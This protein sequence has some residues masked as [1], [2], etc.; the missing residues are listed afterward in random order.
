M[1]KDAFLAT[2][3]GLGLG[4]LVTGIF[5]LGPQLAKSLPHITFPTITFPQAKPQKQI[6]PTPTPMPI[7]FAVSSPLPES[8]EL[9]DQLVVSGTAPSDSLVVVQG[10]LDDDVIRVNGDG[11]YAAK[12]TLAEGKNDLVVTNYVK[13]KHAVQTVT[14][15]Y[16]AENL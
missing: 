8:I 7:V 16:T 3:I 14:V 6:A 10:A 15:Y 12:V 13:E 11:K 1:N 2:L 9:S 4:L 5:I